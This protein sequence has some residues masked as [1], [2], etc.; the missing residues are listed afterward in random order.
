MVTP[1]KSR[2]PISLRA[3]ENAV[4]KVQRLRKIELPFEV[5]GI[6][7]VLRPLHLEEEVEAQEYATNEL[8]KL[9]EGEATKS[10]YV[11]F[12]DRLRQST[13]GFS[14]VQIGDLDLRE[15]DFI[16]TQETNEEGEAVRFSIPKW[17]A[18]RDLIAHEW[19]R[20]MLNQVFAKFGELIERME[21]HAAKSVKFDAVD[22]EEELERAQ[23]RLKELQ[24]AKKRAEEGPETD[25]IQTQQHL[26][27][28]A[29]KEQK[30]HRDEILYGRRNAAEEGLDTVTEEDEGQEPPEASQRSSEAGPEEPAP[31]PA[32]PSPRRPRPTHDAAE[33]PSELSQGQR[34][35]AIPERGVPP[36]RP[37][38]AAPAPRDPRLVDRHG[39]EL[40]HEGDSFYDSSDPDAAI[41]VETRRQAALIREKAERDQRL[42][43]EAAARDAKGRP[44]PRVEARDMMRKRQR[45]GEVPKGAT[46]VGRPVENLREAANLNDAVFDAGGGKIMR[47]RPA[48]PA[49]SGGGG[50]P[51]RLHGKEVHRMP[52][53]T[54]ER[55][56]TR[57]MPAIDQEGGSQ[58]P[59]FRRPG[60]T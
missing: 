43:A 48:Q 1:E 35:S 52:T 36:V 47:G 31:E 25:L 20:P 15:V 12:M 9:K 55:P 46:S 23:R 16:E 11:D 24:A 53:Q 13:L 57:T 50:K 22:L 7:L 29:Q 18:I 38:E 44:D 14:L 33:M 10:D 17:E 19:S 34:R 39:F 58:N 5:D 21:L 30:R 6:P 42:E 56:V 8:L 26:T 32:A 3:L 59:R 45:V 60:D 54:L 37:E 28:D 51:V 49:P 41:E 40:P 27:V 2:R 4:S